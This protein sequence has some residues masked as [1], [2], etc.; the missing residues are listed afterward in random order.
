METTY[1]QPPDPRGWIA[2]V[3]LGKVDL[4]DSGLRSAPDGSGDGGGQKRGRTRG[5]DEGAATT[6]TTVT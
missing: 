2:D 1:R 3:K 5:A 6:L 4:D